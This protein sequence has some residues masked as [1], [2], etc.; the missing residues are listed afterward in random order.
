MS[1]YDIAIVTVELVKKKNTF[2]EVKPDSFLYSIEMHNKNLNEYT[3]A[4]I[5]NGAY[6]I[7]MNVPGTY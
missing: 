6:A 4:P 1:G 7:A 2:E 5:N 3:N